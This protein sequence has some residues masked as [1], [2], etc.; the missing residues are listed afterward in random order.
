[1]AKKKDFIIENYNGTDYDTLYPQTNSGQVLLDSDAQTSTNLESGS[2]LDDALAN[3]G[4]NSAAFQVGDTL[5]TART[6]LDDKWALCNSEFLDFAKYPEIKGILPKSNFDF[7][8]IGKPSTQIA[9]NEAT[10]ASNADKENEQ[11][12]IVFGSGSGN[13]LYYGNNPADS[14]TWTIMTSIG[15]GRG[16]TKYV[17]GIWFI[18]GESA[19][20][21]YYAGDLASANFVNVQGLSVIDQT[22]VIYT[23]DRYYIVGRN[24]VYIYSDLTENP[25]IIS[26]FGNGELFGIIPEG[27]TVGM[28][29]TSGTPSVRI[30]KSDTTYEDVNIKN[31]YNSVLLVN[32]LTYYKN[33]YY[34]FISSTSNSVWKGDS[35]DSQFELVKYEDG[36]AVDMSSF[37]RHGQVPIETDVGLVS[38]N[39]F[40]IDENGTAHKW[41]NDVSTEYSSNIAVGAENYYYFAHPTSSTETMVAYA[42]KQPIVSS[43]KLPSVSIADKL[44]TYM[45]VKSKNSCTLTVNVTPDDATIE[46]KDAEGNVVSQNEG[47]TNVFTLSN[48][49]GEY[50]VTVSKDGYTSQTTTIQ[51]TKNQELDITLVVE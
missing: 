16:F 8:E 5:T 15:S 48:I 4:K 49:T 50:T 17:N 7:L 22:D 23:N 6:D 14:S 28:L 36:S 44:Y 12:L 32:Y 30:I 31:T 10:I 45:K 20:M 21:Q 19:I 43:A 34:A 51:N 26:G 47:S 13:G 3:I 18:Y 41:D 40:Y 39:G 9:W 11:F 24:S 38:P 27:V 35:L 46:V 29:N 2:T 33:K 42:Y 37:A 25:I 1:M